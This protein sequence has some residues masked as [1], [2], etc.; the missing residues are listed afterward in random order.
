MSRQLRVLIIVENLRSP[1][2]AVSGRRRRSATTISPS[3][4]G[5]RGSRA[6]GI[7]AHNLQGAT[8]QINLA[9]VGFLFVV[10]DGRG[11]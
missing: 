1:S 5:S 10:E 4:R 6:S 11:A 2:I 7:G 8:K 9:L 3:C